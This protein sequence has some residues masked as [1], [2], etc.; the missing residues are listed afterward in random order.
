[1]CAVQAEQPN[2]KA[3]R[4][5]SSFLCTIASRCSIRRGNCGQHIMHMSYCAC[6][7]SRRPHLKVLEEEFGSSAHSCAV[8]ARHQHSHRHQSIYAP[9]VVYNSE[10]GCRGFV[11]GLLV[12][13]SSS[14]ALTDAVG[15]QAPQESCSW[16]QALSDWST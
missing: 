9:A 5:K 8:T 11:Q 6:S 13:C 4:T 2:P 1:M 16:K 10:Y 15:Q 12:P 3:F 7:G 14:F